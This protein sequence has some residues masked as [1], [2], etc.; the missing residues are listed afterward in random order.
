MAHQFL[1]R[2]PAVPDGIGQPPASH[3]STNGQRHTRRVTTDADLSMKLE[4]PLGFEPEN[5]VF[6][7]SLEPVVFSIGRARFT[8]WRRI[9]EPPA[10]PPGWTSRS[11]YS[12]I[13]NQ[14]LHERPGKAS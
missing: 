12:S 3:R 5:E 8:T 7:T 10:L 6:Q 4:A 9:S 2:G 14:W 1:S 11:R 13:L